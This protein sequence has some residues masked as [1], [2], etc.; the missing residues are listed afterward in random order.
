V[1]EPNARFTLTQPGV[2]AL[3]FLVSFRKDGQ[4][5]RANRSGAVE[6]ALLE[7]AR[8]RG[9][10]RGADPRPAVPGPHV[11]DL[12]RMVRVHF[13]WLT[14]ESD[15]SS[16]EKDEEAERRWKIVE[17]SLELLEAIGATL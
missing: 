10:N 14:T 5:P 15:L 7:A 3:E 8:A 13:D 1:A 6:E 16:A 9:W 2:D 17:R 4:L 12:A 11:A